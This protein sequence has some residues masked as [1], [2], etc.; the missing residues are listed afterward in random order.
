MPCRFS[1]A[2]S[3]CIDATLIVPLPPISM[4]FGIFT[5]EP[6]RERQRS[7]SPVSFAVALPDW[8]VRKSGIGSSSV[9]CNVSC[10]AVALI[11]PA[12]SRSGVAVAFVGKNRP[13][14]ANS[15]LRSGSRNCVVAS[16]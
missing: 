15:R 10:T 9:N 14:P 12:S 4:L 5:N 16:A 11:S 1:F 8:S 13:V 6:M 3:N 7:R 2:A